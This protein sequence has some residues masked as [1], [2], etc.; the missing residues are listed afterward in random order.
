MQLEDNALYVMAALLIISGIVSYINTRKF[1]RNSSTVIG[2]VTKK[3]TK[4]DSTSDGVLL[5]LNAEFEVNGKI[6]KLAGKGA[7]LKK[8]EIGN[9]IEIL[10]DKDNPSHAHINHFWQLYLIEFVLIGIGVGVISVT[11]LG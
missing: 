11:F 2:K 9:D 10:F 4:L 6:Y 8:Y 1:I 7:N 5:V 3:F